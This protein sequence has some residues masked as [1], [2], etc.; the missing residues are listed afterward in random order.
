MSLS[1][2]W[3]TDSRQ[4]QLHAQ[5]RRAAQ[6]YSRT[7]RFRCGFTSFCKNDGTD[8]LIFFRWSGSENKD[9]EGDGMV[10]TKEMLIGKQKIHSIDY[11]TSIFA[12]NILFFLPALILL[13]SAVGSCLLSCPARNKIMN[14]KSTRNDLFMWTVRLEEKSRRRSRGDKEAVMSSILFARFLGRASARLSAFLTGFWASSMFSPTY[15]KEK[16]C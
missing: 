3:N 14:P 1:T 9:E 4:R 13:M 11:L 16:T 12:K 7:E 15:W 8:L 10:E 6:I 5:G 2:S